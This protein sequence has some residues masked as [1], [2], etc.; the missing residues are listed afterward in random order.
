EVAQ[1]LDVE[2]VVAVGVER[3]GALEVG[4]DVIAA[5]RVERGHPL[6]RLDGLRVALGTGP[7]AA[8]LNQLLGGVAEAQSH[9]G[10]TGAGRVAA[11][12][13]VADGAADGG[14]AAA[15]VGIAAVKTV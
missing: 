15:G 11:I 13:V 12:P 14:V 6:H 2:A 10:R 3:A 5:I 9:A 7:G 1:A 4:R 8:G